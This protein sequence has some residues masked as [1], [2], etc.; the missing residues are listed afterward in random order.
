MVA[1]LRYDRACLL[2]EYSTVS[3]PNAVQQRIQDVGLWP[4]RR[5][6]HT[7]PHQLFTRRYRGKR[8]GRSRRRTPSL[9][10][11]GNGSFVVTCRH[12]RGFMNEN[13][14][15]PINK[16]KSILST[17]RKSALISII[18]VKSSLTNDDVQRW[19]SQRSVSWQQG[20]INQRLHC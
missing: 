3:L 20:C 1:G 4:V 9:R 6:V 12:T 17:R 18:N 11:V 2:S 19:S 5:P 16:S 14:R 7:S 15:Q 8:A 10:P 13:R